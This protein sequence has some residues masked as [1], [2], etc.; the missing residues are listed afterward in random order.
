MI[1]FDYKPYIKTDKDG[2]LIAI[3]Y[4]P[5]AI[6]KLTN[7]NH[8]VTSN[9]IVDSGADISIIPKSEGDLLGFRIEEG[10][11]VKDISGIGGQIP[12]LYRTVDMFIGAENMKIK[13]AWALVDDLP[14]I[15][16]REDIFDNFNIEFRQKDKK[17]IF[18]K[19]Q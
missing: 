4:R 10:E 8:S 5:N 15:L 13:V 11:E 3:Y 9:M 14:P 17:I 1:Q 16:G 18:H 19:L 7:G 12:I 2:E 6:I